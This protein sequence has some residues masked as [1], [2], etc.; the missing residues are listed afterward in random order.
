MSIIPKHRSHYFLQ[1]SF[2]T[3]VQLGSKYAIP[4]IPLL[5]Q[6]IAFTKLLNTLL[7][8]DITLLLANCYYLEIWKQTKLSFFKENLA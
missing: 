6:L 7:K 4:D 2:V 1:K 8:K 3:D 5:S